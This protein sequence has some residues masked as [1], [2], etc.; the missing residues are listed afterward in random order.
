[1]SGSGFTPKTV[2]NFFFQSGETDVNLGGLNP[3][4]EPIIRATIHGPTMLSF[5]V[6]DGAAP[7]RCYVQAANPPFTDNLNSGTG[8]GGSFVLQAL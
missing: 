7:G 2:V 3:R 8:A 6:P 1:V 4:G 5:S